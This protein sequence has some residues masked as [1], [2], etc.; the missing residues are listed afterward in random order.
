[1]DINEIKASIIQILLKEGV[2][3]KNITH[4]DNVINFT[5]KKDPIVYNI[6]IE[7]ENNIHFG[8][9]E[10][11]NREYSSNFLENYDVYGDINYTEVFLH[12]IKHNK[13]YECLVKVWDKLEKIENE[14]S[15]DIVRNIIKDIYGFE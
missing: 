14:Y 5:Y 8:I 10:I 3:E 6:F 11:P 15:Y 2:V 13:D 12:D 4:D 7:D 9:Y 1:M